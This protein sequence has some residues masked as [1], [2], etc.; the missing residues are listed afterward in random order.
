DGGSP[1]SGS[2]QLSNGSAAFTTSTLALGSHSI[3]ARYTGDNQHGPSVSPAL[4]QNVV[5][6]NSSVSVSLTAGTNPAFTGDSLTFI[7]TVTPT[8]ATGFIV[9]F[10]GGTAISGNLPVIAGSA[11]LTTSTLSVGAHSITAQYSGDASFN[12]ATSAALSQ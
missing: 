3:N 9:F 6:G 2:I 12:A 7:A 5:K 11:S 10:D 4:V 1:L 8:A